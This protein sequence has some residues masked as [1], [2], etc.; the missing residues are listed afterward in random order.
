[1]APIVPWTRHA[2]HL[3]RPSGRP[4]AKIA[5]ERDL[6][7][8]G[9]RLLDATRDRL[10]QRRRPTR[11]RMRALVATPGGRMR[12]HSIAAPPPPGPDAAVVH[13]IA[14]A[15]CDMTGRPGWG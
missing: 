7:V 8:R 6:D 11:P 1:M 4:A 3:A 15:T 12:W 13:P 9:R 2:W 5:M 10:A 14:I